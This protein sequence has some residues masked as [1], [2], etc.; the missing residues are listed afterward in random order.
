[1]HLTNFMCHE[2]FTINFHPRVN[3]LVGRNGSG[4]S[5]ILAALVLGLGGKAKAT[6]RSNNVKGY[7]FVF[8]PDNEY[9]P[10]SIIF[11]YKIKV[12]DN[13]NN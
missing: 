9:N 11:M 5:A 6:N 2:N 4:K 8:V 7:I 10:I 3:F 13:K 12:K 1:M